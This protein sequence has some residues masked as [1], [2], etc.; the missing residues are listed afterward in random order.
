MLGASA[1][2]GLMTERSHTENAQQAPV[3]G[4]RIPPNGPGKWALPGREG[5]CAAAAGCC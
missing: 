1:T 3:S 5:S 4:K 2:A